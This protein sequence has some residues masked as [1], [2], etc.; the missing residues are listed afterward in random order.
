MP[1]SVHPLV[2]RGQIMIIGKQY[3]SI[4]MN[5]AD[6]MRMMNNGHTPLYTRHMLGVREL[7]RDKRKYGR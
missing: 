5:E 2:P 7:E 4:L 6:F 1:I 3:G